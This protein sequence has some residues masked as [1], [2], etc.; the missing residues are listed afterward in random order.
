M[1]SLVVFV[2]LATRTWAAVEVTP[3]G[4]QARAMAPCRL[5][6]ALTVNVALAAGQ[7]ATTGSEKECESDGGTWAD[8]GDG[9]CDRLNARSQCNWDGGDCGDTPQKC[10]AAGGYPIYM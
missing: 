6:L 9:R 8:V 2:T 5:L 7:N 1:L 3:H 10:N 4:S